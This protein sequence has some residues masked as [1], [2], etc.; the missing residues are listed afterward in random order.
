MKLFTWIILSC[1]I[2]LFVLVGIGLIAFSLHGIPVESTTWALETAYSEKN[3]RFAC[4]LA[5]EP[6]FMS[7]SSVMVAPAGS[8]Q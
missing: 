7:S 6:D 5:G 8:S 1:Y 2:V 4:F 3:L